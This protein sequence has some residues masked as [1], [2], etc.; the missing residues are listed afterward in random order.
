MNELPL[1]RTLL[2]TLNPEVTELKLSVGTERGRQSDIR[3][4][5]EVFST[6]VVMVVSWEQRSHYKPNFINVCIICFHI[7][8]TIVTMLPQLQKKTGGEK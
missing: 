1:R 8:F 3:K 7:V 5:G 2:K 6:V 4:T